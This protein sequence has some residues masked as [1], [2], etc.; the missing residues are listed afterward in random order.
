MT[1]TRAPIPPP[2]SSPAPP[3]VATQA[4]ASPAATAAPPAQVAPAAA[5]SWLGEWDFRAD[6]GKGVVAGTLRFRSAGVGIAGTYVGLRGNTTEL[7]N[8]SAAGDRISFDLVTPRAVWHLVGT[9]SGDR[10]EGT[11]QT[12]EHTIPWSAVRTGT[13]T[14]APRTPSRP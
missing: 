6:A 5:T 12:A 9:L 7:S 13:G 1:A 4:P 3:I 2:T 14:A 10:I 8:L 11:F